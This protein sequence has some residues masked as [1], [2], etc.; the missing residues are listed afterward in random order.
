MLAAAIAA[1][2]VKTV[3]NV[4]LPNG[5]ATVTQA[6]DGAITVKTAKTVAPR[7]IE[8]IKID[9]CILSFEKDAGIDVETLRALVIRET[10]NP[11]YPVITVL[12]KCSVGVLTV[13][14]EKSP[15]SRINSAI[16]R[17]ERLRKDAW[18]RGVK[19]SADVANAHKI[20]AM[21]HVSEKGLYRIRRMV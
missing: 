3:A 6:T 9:G 1:E 14:T 5:T 17:A 18:N 4:P 11:W 16:A 2:N 20:V 21:G 15:L 8:S 13:R 12:S 19:P 10:T 7:G